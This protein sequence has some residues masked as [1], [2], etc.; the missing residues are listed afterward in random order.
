MDF[1]GDEDDE[2]GDY[3][4]T[5]VGARKTRL[6]MTFKENYKIRNAPSKAQDVKHTH[7][8]WEVCGSA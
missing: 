1:I 3:A 6:D 4:L 2:T 7:E 5:S 8:L